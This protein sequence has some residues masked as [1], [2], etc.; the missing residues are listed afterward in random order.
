[1]TYIY[2]YIFHKTCWMHLLDSMSWFS[3]DFGAVDWFSLILFIYRHRKKENLG[4][5]IN[6]KMEFQNERNPIFILLDRPL[7]KYLILFGPHLHISLS[8]LHMALCLCVWGERE[9]EEKRVA[10]IPWLNKFFF[11][12]FWGGDHLVKN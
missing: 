2:I 1:M 8:I 5:S 6:W 11:F 12:F 10:Y 4:I 3:L 9:R 7:I